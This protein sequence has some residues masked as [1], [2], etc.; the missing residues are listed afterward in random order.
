MCLHLP[1][2][3]TSGQQQWVITPTQM[4]GTVTNMWLDPYFTIWGRYHVY[5]IGI[6][7]GW[8]ISSYRTTGS[9]TRFLAKSAVSRSVTVLT[10]W[11]VCAA[12]LIIPMYLMTWCFTVDFTNTEALSNTTHPEMKWEAVTGCAASNVSSSIWNASHRI[13]WGIGVGVLIILCDVGYGFIAQTFLAAKPFM[14]IGK[15]SY[16]IYIFH[17][18]IIIVYGENMKEQ[19]YIDEFSLAWLCIAMLT[20]V[21]AVSVIPYLM[22]E[23]P[24]ATL[25]SYVMVSLVGHTNRKRDKSDQIDQKLPTQ[26]ISEKP[27]NSATTL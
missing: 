10:A 27:E 16:C 23:M 8:F 20:S 13:M 2:L 19:V 6:L 3:L 5:G 9:L 21:I 15:L 25:W 24:I 17:Y 1:S 11:V 14:V 12:C 26:N 22:F 4:S 18:Y 7:F